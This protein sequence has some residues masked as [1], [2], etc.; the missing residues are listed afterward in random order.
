MAKGKTVINCTSVSSSFLGDSACL[1]AV[2]LVTGGSDGGGKV[3]VWTAD[4]LRKKL[5]DL[6]YQIHY[7]SVDYIDGRL[8]LCGSIDDIKCLKGK[9][10]PLTKGTLVYC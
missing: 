5:S 6:P 7:H 8:I 10:Q 3:E 9:Y 4:G 1:E 2:A